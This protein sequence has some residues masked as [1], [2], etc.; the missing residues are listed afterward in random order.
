MGNSNRISCSH[1]HTSR[2]TSTPRS[3][4]CLFVRYQTQRTWESMSEDIPYFSFISLNILRLHI[5]DSELE[6]YVLYEF[7]DCLNHYS[8]SLTD[9]GLRLP[10]EHLMSVLRNR[11]LMEEKTYDRQLLINARDQLLPKL[12][13][14][15]LYIFNLIIGACRNNQQELVFVY[16]HSGTG[17]TFLWKTILYT[18]RSEGK[19]VLAVAS[20]GIASLLLLVGQTTHSRFKI[21]LNL[22]DTTSPMN[23][24]W[25]FETLDR[26]LRDV[27]D[28]PS[29][30][31]SGKS[32]MLGGN[33]RQTLPVKKAA[34]RDEIIR[35]SVAK[36]YLW[37]HFNVYYLTRNMRLKNENLSKVD[38]Q[39]ILSFA[40]WLL[41]VGNGQIGTPDESNPENTS[42]VDIPSIVFLMVMK[43]WLS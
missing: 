25:C 29:R 8:K 41:D 21:P 7:D 32:V 20:S 2:V 36:S 1:C 12:N 33:F 18:L 37:P 5:D 23:D 26:T 34:T 38:R 43:E 17:K 13:E 35:S 42:W 15:Q 24:R 6:D 28:E 14:K 30:I 39:R 4:P 19:V 22:T 27:L 40:Q 10:P 16:G 3:H 31:F 11:L 9:F